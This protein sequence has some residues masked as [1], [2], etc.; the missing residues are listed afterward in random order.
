MVSAG[1]NK[2]P[3]DM[4]TNPRVPQAELGREG[5][6]NAQPC[7]V[8]VSFLRAPFVGTIEKDAHHFRGVTKGQVKTLNA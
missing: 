8:G 1:C 6:T 5:I 7:H 3:K 2:Q 4:K